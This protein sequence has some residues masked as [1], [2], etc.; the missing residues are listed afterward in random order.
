MHDTFG[1]GAQPGP[2]PGVYAPGEGANSGPGLMPF[3]GSSQKKRRNAAAERIK[4]TFNPWHLVLVFM[5]LFLYLSY[6]S[7]KE[8]VSKRRVRKHK[9]G[10][11]GDLREARARMTTLE[12]DLFVR[13]KEHETLTRELDS[14]RREHETTKHELEA[15]KIEV[16]EHVERAA[17]KP[18]RAGDVSTC[19]KEVKTLKTEMELMRH[20]CRVTELEL[21]RAKHEAEF[22]KEHIR[23][24]VIKEDIEQLEKQIEIDEKAEAAAALRL[25]KKYRTF[26]DRTVNSILFIRTVQLYL[27]DLPFYRHRATSSL[28]LLD[29]VPP[30]LVELSRFSTQ[31]E[32]QPEMI[33]RHNG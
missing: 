22:M 7:R 15:K 18:V 5:T 6:Y 32:K 19:Q 9:D 28:R 27:S 16:K 17:S 29:V 8:V 30:A 11:E 14:M 21:E 12:H 13:N 26:R 10:L 33:T 1:Y 24:E 2:A 4:K 23:E 20:K 25:A 3:D 31:R